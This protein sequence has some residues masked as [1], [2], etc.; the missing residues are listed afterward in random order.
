LLD[1]LEGLEPTAILAT[2]TLLRAG[3]NEKNN[4][5][6]VNLRESYAQAER[7]ASGIPGVRFGMVAR[8]EIKHKL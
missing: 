3:L 4:P 5:D 2:K 6:A 7:F 1:E 8:K